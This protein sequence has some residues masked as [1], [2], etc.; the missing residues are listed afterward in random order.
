[1]ILVGLKQRLKQ[2]DLNE[3]E[4]EDLLSQIEKIESDMELN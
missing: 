4:R 1:M 2:D 3:A